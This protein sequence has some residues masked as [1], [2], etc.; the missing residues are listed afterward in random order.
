MSDDAALR[1]LLENDPDA[2]GLTAEEYRRRT[3]IES[4]AAESADT[5]RHLPLALAE[6]QHHCRACDCRSDARGRT[7]A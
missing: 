5:K 3:G 1:W 4:I 7:V 2:A 6:A